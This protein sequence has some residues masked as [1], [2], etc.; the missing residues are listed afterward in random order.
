MSW[1]YFYNETEKKQAAFILFTSKTQ[2]M[3][4]IRINEQLK[5]NSIPDPKNCSLKSTKKSNV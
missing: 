5:R 4:N 3:Q 1:N 2:G